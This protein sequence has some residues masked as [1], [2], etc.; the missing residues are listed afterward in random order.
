MKTR[1]VHAADIH[2]GFRQY[3]S[4]QRY[5][6]FAA[7][8][9]HLVDAT[10]ER[11]ADFLLIAGDLFHKRAIDPLTLWQATSM[12][13]RLHDAGIPAYVVQGNHERPQPGASTSWLDYLAELGL[14]HLLSAHY[15][16]G[17]IVVDPWSA[18][19]A[20]GAYVD[21]PG[22]LRILGLHY[23]GSSTGVA[24][25]DL[26][27]KLQASSEPR[28]AYTILMLHA[29]L[30]GIL[31]SYSATLS[32]VQLDPLHAYVDYMAMGHIHKPFRQDDWIY[33]PGSPETTSVTEVA[34]EDRGYFVVDVDTS[35]SPAHV[36]TAVRNP[37][38]AFLRYPFA[39]AG[40]DTPEDL[41]DALLRHLE[42]EA[43]PP[44]CASRPVVEVELMG[45]LPF[46]R[47]DLD[48][49]ALEARVSE[50][51][52]AT[53]C[54]IRD[55]TSP[56]DY[57]VGP[58]EGLTRPELERHVLRELVERD[59]RYRAQSAAWASLVLRVKQMVLTGSGPGEIVEELAALTAA[60][61]DGAPAP[62]GDPLC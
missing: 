36:V 29:G 12:L 37:R 26:A 57:D 18:E 15:Q 52:G 31:D 30:Q 32:R 1:F 23:M 4:D 41:S 6:D 55:E 13:M 61:F 39:V 60:I 3:G 28:P 34:W 24:V 14:V 11:R 45:S 10:I 56:A 43:T 16:E 48:V 25:R 5:N 40:H 51:F 9:D 17:E 44:L 46:S 27:A 21:L 19:S 53:V 42:R 50:M 22:G 54:R 38:R 49:A 62:E 33:N 20:R 35:R 8:F 59:V 58:T 2:L 7:A 47:G